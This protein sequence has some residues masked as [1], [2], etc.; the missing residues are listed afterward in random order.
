VP[1]AS[2]LGHPYNLVLLGSVLRRRAPVRPGGAC[3]STS[4]NSVNAKF[5]EFTFRNCLKSPYEYRKELHEATK[6]DE[7]TL[8]S[9][10]LATSTRTSDIL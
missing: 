3:E 7:N 9:P 10:F 6:E 1:F 5:A 4:E 2:F 8:F